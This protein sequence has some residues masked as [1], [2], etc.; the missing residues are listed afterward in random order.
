MKVQ[1]SIVLSLLVIAAGAETE[2]DPC[3]D[4]RFHMISRTENAYDEK[5]MIAFDSDRDGNWEIYV[6]STDG[7]TQRRITDNPAADRHPSWSPDGSMLAFESERDG[8]WEIYLM[9]M[10]GSSQ[11]RLTSNSYDDNFPS[12]APDGS[13]I[14]FSTGRDGHVEAYVMNLDGSNQRRITDSVINAKVP[15]W[16]PDGSR[17]IIESDTDPHLG[18]DVDIFVIDLDGTNLVRL[19][20]NSDANGFPSWSPDGAL[21]LFDWNRMSISVM[22]ST[23]TNEK[24]L[25]TPLYSVERQPAYEDRHARWSPDGS[26]IVFETNRHGHWDVYSMRIDGSDQTRLTSSPGNDRFPSWSPNLR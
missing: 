2:H 9:N 13:R 1:L 26:K 23:G 22:D 10:D 15:V 18:G 12:W 7:S 21:I 20:D 8:N 11:R 4:T 17:V 16:S 19:T 24:K 14:A 25:S 5:S 6:M 3:D